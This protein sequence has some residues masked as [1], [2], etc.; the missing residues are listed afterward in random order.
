M[1]A[2]GGGRETGPVHRE[3]QETG[4]TTAGRGRNPGPSGLTEEVKVRQV[5]AEVPGGLVP[6]ADSTGTLISFGTQLNNAHP[7]GWRDRP[8]EAPATYRVSMLISGGEA[9]DMVPSP[10]RGQG[11][12]WERWGR[13]SS[14]VTT[15]TT[16]TPSAA[17]GFGYATGLSCRECGQVYELGPLYACGECF[18]PLEVRY[19]YP[20][21]D[22]SAM[23]GGTGSSAA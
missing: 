9:R 22:R 12:R 16:R 19:D 1:A 23:S 7:E 15:A 2:R 18:G 3:A 13:K 10:A 4:G 6:C 17:C 20:R 5:S 11:D 21:L 8:C 14:P